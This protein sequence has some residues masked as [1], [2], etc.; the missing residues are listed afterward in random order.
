MI[1]INE[2][3]SVSG[4]FESSG[5]SKSTCWDIFVRETQGNETRE[6]RQEDAIKVGRTRWSVNGYIGIKKD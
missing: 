6:L 4:F 1:Y 5:F 2:N 3:S